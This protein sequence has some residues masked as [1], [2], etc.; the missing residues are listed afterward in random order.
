MAYIQMKNKVEVSDATLLRLPRYLKFL[1]SLEMKNVE[2]VSSTDIAEGLFLNAVQVRKD[3]GFVS[4]EGGKPKVGFNTKELIAD[5]ESFLE[6]DNTHDA[7]IVGVG[8]LGKAF[9]GYRGFANY[10]LN[11]VAGFDVNDEVCGKT[12]NTKQ[13]LHIS[14]L[15][16]YVKRLNIK[17]GIIA[18]PNQFAQQTADLLID[19]GIKGIWNFANT[20]IDVPA[21]I[22][23]KN[24][25]LAASLA[26]LSMKLKSGN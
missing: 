9:L 20:H 7:I 2:Y 24:E 11:I 12:I 8:A 22:E 10:G 4:T 21:G 1:Q 25:D 19:S 23:L 26:L 13:V 6:Y 3:L 5:I 18:T 14:K 15:K 17:L 16:D